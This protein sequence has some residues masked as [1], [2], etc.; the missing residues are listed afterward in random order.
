MKFVVYID[1]IKRDLPVHAVSFN[2]DTTFVPIENMTSVPE[3]IGITASEKEIF[4]IRQSSSEIKVF[5]C[6]TFKFVRNIS[7]TGLRDPCDIT[8]S[9][10]ALFVGESASKLIHR[11]PLNSAESMSSWSVDY[12]WFSLSTMKS[13]NILVTSSSTFELM[14]YTTTGTLVREIPL[15]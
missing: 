13:S 4:V 8:Y 9:E 6:D 14:E 7:A 3:V 10:N 12:E 2:E 15:P 5:D 11:I 1:S